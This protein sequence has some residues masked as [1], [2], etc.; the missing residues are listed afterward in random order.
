MAD[1]EWKTAEMQAFARSLNADKDGRRLKRE[2]QAQFDSITE[3]L[4]D[5]LRHQTSTIQ[6]AGTY[7]AVAA[8]GMKFT[9][10]LIGG[11]RARVSVVGEGKTAKGKWRELGRFLDDGILMHPAWGRWISKPPPSSLMMRVPD[12][13]R[14]VTDALADSE[15]NIRDEIRIVLTEYLDRLTDIRKAQA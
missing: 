15:P 4:R 10:K 9:T 2:M 13:P 3:D 1:I 6:G 11:R 5:R 8:E 12:A 14:A 7:P